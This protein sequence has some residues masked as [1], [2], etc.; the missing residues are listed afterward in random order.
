MIVGPP[1]GASNGGKIPGQSGLGR[2]RN[3]IVHQGGKPGSMD[4]FGK[5]NPRARKV[6][7]SV[8]RNR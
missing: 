7:E 3:T 2:N 6:I 8:E 4:P 1:T 5:I